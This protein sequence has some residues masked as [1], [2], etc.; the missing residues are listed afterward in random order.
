MFEGF[1]GPQPPPERGDVEPVRD[2]ATS[3][4]AH[5]WPEHE[6]L[7]KHFMDQSTSPSGRYMEDE[8]GALLVWTGWKPKSW[9]A[10]SIES[11]VD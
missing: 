1:L 6:A 7:W 2:S 11:I 3:Q 9:K 5:K 8:T 10:A 4:E